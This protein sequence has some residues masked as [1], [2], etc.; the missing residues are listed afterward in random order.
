MILLRI[1]DHDLHR[2]R[3][4]VDGTVMWIETPAKPS[5]LPAVVSL[6][7][8]KFAVT[9]KFA[10]GMLRSGVFKHDQD[11]LDEVVPDLMLAAYNLSVEEKWD[12]IHKT[13]ASAFSWLQKKSGTT[14]QPH[15]VL[16]PTS[17][18]KPKFSKWAGKDNITYGATIPGSDGSKEVVTVYKKVCRVQFCNVAF[19]VF[20]S[21][22]DFVGMY[23]QILGGRS[24]ILL[25]NTRN[26]M[27]FCP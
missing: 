25:H 1:L 16:V 20:L 14:S 18:S 8:P 27:A 7:T 22:P 26:S 21:R 23:T 6:S 2:Y 17:W 15:C 9:R 3:R 24:S 12:N 13:A 10:N 11:R 4:G 19:P 5:F